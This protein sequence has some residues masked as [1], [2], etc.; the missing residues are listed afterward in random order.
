LL[1]AFDKKSAEALQICLG[2]QTFTFL[3]QQVAKLAKSLKIPDGTV[4]VDSSSDSKQE[5]GLA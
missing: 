3:D 2:K 4:S 1:D 5:E